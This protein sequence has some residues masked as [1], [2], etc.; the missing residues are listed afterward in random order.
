MLRPPRQWT[1]LPDAAFRDI[2]EVTE[3]KLPDVA[4]RFPRRQGLL[5]ILER[6]AVI[7][8]VVIRPADVVVERGEPAL[9]A[10]VAGVFGHRQ[11]FEIPAQALVGGCGDTQHVCGIDREKIFVRGE[12][13][14]E[15]L[16]EQRHRALRLER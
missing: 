13:L 15:R 12:R 7:T 9:R 4:T 14:L 8:A 10:R 5:E 1:A 2:Y 6:S 16:T 11:G 3:F